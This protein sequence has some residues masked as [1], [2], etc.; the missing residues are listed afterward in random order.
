[1][2]K[3]EK[4]EIAN[5]KLRAKVA[6]LERDN[7]RL[8]DLLDAIDDVLSCEEPQ[9]T[10]AQHLAQIDNILNHDH[11]EAPPTIDGN[12]LLR[13]V[14]AAFGAAMF[15]AMNEFA[16]NRRPPGG[17]APA[18]ERKQVKQLTAYDP[19]YHPSK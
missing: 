8:V 16:Q 3:T 19:M 12:E 7:D 1:M 18:R 15:G 2:N 17:R 6:E 10:D 11:Q 4:L 9:H 5:A 14:A 13:N